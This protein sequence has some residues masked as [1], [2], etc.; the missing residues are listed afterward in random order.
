[1]T[2]GITILGPGGAQPNVRLTATDNN[3]GTINSLTMDGTG[4]NAGSGTLRIVSG[5]ILNLTGANSINATS[6][7]IGARN[8]TQ[9]KDNLAAADLRLSAEQ[10]ARL[11]AASAVRPA[12]PYWHQRRTFTQR[13]PP[14]V[15]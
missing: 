5:G 6:V 9:L 1:V 8:V 11:D 12:Y 7:V 4:I 15:A 13:N 3:A 10:I 2:S 14:P